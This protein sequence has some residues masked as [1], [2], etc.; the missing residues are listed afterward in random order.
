MN[1]QPRTRTIENAHSS[2]TVVDEGALVLQWAPAGADQVLFVHPAVPV[3]HGKPPHAGVPV[4]WPWFG[5]GPADEAPTHGFA[6][7]A[8]WRHVATTTE[9][10]ATSV[11]YLLTSDD[12]TSEWWPHPY[13]LRLVVSFGEVLEVSLTTT[14]D[15]PDPVVVGE[16]LH[17][18]LAV[19]DVREITVTGLGGAEY[20][21]KVRGVTAVQAGDLVLTEEADRV[22]R[23][24]AAVLVDDPVLGRRLRVESEGAAN[25]VVWNP[26]D[27]KARDLDDVDEAW[28]RFVCVEAANA[29]DDVVTVA[30]GAAHTLTYRITVEDL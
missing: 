20:F 4:C 8:E 2:G 10:G 9:A 27:D 28:P 17:A 13:R 25:R 5:P 29:R 11:E 26:W 23:S 30:P 1:E 7:T 3:R 15:G 18:Y 24:A 22:Y 12:A 6:R 21:D 14:N 16:A 19:G